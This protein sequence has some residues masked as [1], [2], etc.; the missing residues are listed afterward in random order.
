MLGRAGIPAVLID[1]HPVYPP[2]FRVEKLSGAEQIGRFARTG[3]ADS[4]LRSATRDSGNW[5]A[6]GGYLLDKRPSL[7]FGM[8]YDSLVNTIRSDIPPAVE[9]VCAK[10][11]AI[12]TSAER[13]KLT[14]SN[15]ETISARLV[16]LANGLN[17][18]LRRSLGIE[19][20]VVSPCHSISI[21]FDMAPVGRAAFDFPALT[22]FSERTSDRIPYLSL[23][24]VGERMRANLFAYRESDDP[25]IRQFRAA[26]VETLDAALP[27]L[28][29]ITGEFEV[30]GDIKIRPADLYV[31][32]HYLK[33]G[34]VLVGDAFET[35]C[36][37]TGTGT[38]KVFT[39]VERLCNVHIP[40]WLASDGMDANKIAAFYDDPVK[41]A[42]DAWASAK[43]YNF[44]ALTLE[45][46]IYWSAQRWARFIVWLGQGFLRQILGPYKEPQAMPIPASALIATTS[47][48]GARQATNSTNPISAT[49]KSAGVLTEV[50]HNGL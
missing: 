39:D 30:R 13:Q 46:D 27:R 22:Y 36:P 4:V 5:I 25:W 2:D 49:P 44:R 23:F 8:M 35:T 16:V 41:K 42:C 28:R 3:I 47:N 6:R 32:T 11:I 7:Q 17:I 24:P 1:P 33:P 37:V 15:D 38:D 21:G 14:L 19:R 20:Q 9:R 43:A 18:G 31:S 10:A 34:L 45:K 29:R 50:V 26:P 12:S 40:A 48:G